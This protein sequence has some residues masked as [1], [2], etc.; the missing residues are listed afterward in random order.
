MTHKNSTNKR[1]K[2]RS[3]F[4]HMGNGLFRVITSPVLIVIIVVGI[5]SVIY[6]GWKMIRQIELYYMPFYLTAG[7]VGLVL[8]LLFLLLCLG[9]PR[10]MRQYRSA[11]TEA[12]IVNKV[13]DTPTLIKRTDETNSFDVHI[14][15]LTFDA[16]GVP[17]SEWI[18]KQDAI[19]TALNRH[20]V[21]I[22]QGDK[23]YQIE[24]KTVSA[25]RTIPKTIPWDDN[26]LT[27]NDSFAL[28]MGYEGTISYDVSI[29]P[30]AIIG[31]STGS[32]KSV[33][34]RLLCYQAL[35]KGFHL[36]IIDLKGGLDYTA[37]LDKCH[38]IT[39]E[40]ETE[41]YLKTVVDELDWRKRTFSN[42]GSANIGEFNRKNHTHL[43]HIMI[44][45]DELAELT[46]VKALDK[47]QKERLNR[48][49]GYISTIARLGRAFGLHLVLATQR[50]DANVLPGQIK[51]NCDMRICSR[52]DNV[53]SQIVL[54]STIAADTIPKDE[55]GLFVMP[56]GT[57]F[58][59]FYIADI[60]IRN[61]DTMEGKGDDFLH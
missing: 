16:L 43:R 5:L 33:E 24:L 18:E 13:G 29:I 10:G 59:G 30:H 53:L 4:R 12:G 7:I 37:F 9:T 57:M 58:R 35:R 22:R 21:S 25:D 48:I 23:P 32:G 2:M 19:E 49:I 38:L 52:A 15:T 45:C 42:S 31:G 50:P 28:G 60:Q 20:I 17:L 14:S 39:A 44:V 61:T 56:D 41:R 6:F 11:L 26:Y 1:T 54:D 51:N 34:V 40:D 55:Q 36:A 8:F 3:L 47:E 46:D 27:N